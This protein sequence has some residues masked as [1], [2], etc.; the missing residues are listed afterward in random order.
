MT[1]LYVMDSAVAQFTVRDLNRFVAQF[2][3]RRIPLEELSLFK[4]IVKKWVDFAEGTSEPTAEVTFEPRQRLFPRGTPPHRPGVY[5]IF[6]CRGRGNQRPCFYVGMSA[7]S[8]RRR[9]RR[10]LGGRVRI[11]YAGTFGRLRRCTGVWVCTAVMSGQQNDATKQ[12]LK[13]LEACLTV[14]LRAWWHDE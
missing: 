1:K 8:L 13:T 12:K 9:L 3:N 10:H 5:A 7:S 4:S 11:N 6:C 14:D 2:R